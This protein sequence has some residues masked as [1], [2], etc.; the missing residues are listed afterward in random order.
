[1]MASM[2]FVLLIV[3][4]IGWLIWAL[5]RS[6]VRRA[7]LRRQAEGGRGAPPRI[8]QV[9]NQGGRTPSARSPAG[10]AGRRPTLT[11][12]AEIA[13]IIGLF[14]ALIALIAH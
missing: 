6:S 10:D 11:V 5:V 3:I 4:A 2:P 1:M 12:A 14:I 7:E 13:G 8:P 9:S